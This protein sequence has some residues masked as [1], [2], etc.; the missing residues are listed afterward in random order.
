MV[1]QPVGTPD[2]LTSVY[3]TTL[4]IVCWGKE[5]AD[6]GKRC[7][8]LGSQRLNET[9]RVNGLAGIFPVLFLVKAKGSD[10][11]L[12]QLGAHQTEPTAALSVHTKGQD[13]A[14]W[15]LLLSGR[16]LHSF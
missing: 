1:E 7:T 12:I 8:A 3:N 14:G 15:S 5:S 16:Q 6:W 9:R 10:A 4:H 13:Q 2:V 11:G